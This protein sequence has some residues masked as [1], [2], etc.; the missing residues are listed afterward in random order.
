MARPAHSRAL[1]ILDSDHCIAITRGKLKPE[2]HITNGEPL[3]VTC[4]TVSEM[5]YGA[6]RSSQSSQSL[7]RLNSFLHKF[8]VLSCDENT[9][10]IFSRLKVDLERQGMRLDDADL[11]IASIAILHDATLV[12][13][14]QRHFGRVPGLEL[15]DWLT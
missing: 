1:K 12:T 5:F 6:Y 8:Q 7:A 14:N 11:Y 10:R 9:S 13:H 2:E 3:Y 4:I 15:E